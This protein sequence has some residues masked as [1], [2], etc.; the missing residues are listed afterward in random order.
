MWYVSLGFGALELEPW[1]GRQKVTTRQREVMAGDSVMCRNIFEDE[2]FPWRRRSVE[3]SLWRAVSITLVRPWEDSN[4]KDD[5]AAVS[6]Q[7]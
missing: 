4:V 2:E 1:P 5:I 7:Y 3:R 6:K